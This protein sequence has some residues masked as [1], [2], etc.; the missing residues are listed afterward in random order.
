[1]GKEI[2]WSLDALTVL[3]SAFCIDGIAL[4]CRGGRYQCLWKS[5]L[6]FIVS[7]STESRETRS[8]TKCNTVDAG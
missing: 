5:L 7:A 2:C 3:A 4:C 1:M 8:L 6:Y